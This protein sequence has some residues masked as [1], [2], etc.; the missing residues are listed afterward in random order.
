MHR[1]EN[2]LLQYS[3]VGVTNG[4]KMSVLWEHIRGATN[5]V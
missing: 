4:V 1:H 2:S 3:M 5:L